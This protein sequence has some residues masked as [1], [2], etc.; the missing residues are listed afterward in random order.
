MVKVG[1]VREGGSRGRDR[2][3][4]LPSAT[5]CSVGFGVGKCAWVCKTAAILTTRSPA[6]PRPLSPA[7]LPRGDGQ[8][9]PA[10]TQIIPQQVRGEKDVSVCLCVPVGVCVSPLPP[11]APPGQRADTGKEGRRERGGNVS[12]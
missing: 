12:A 5:T 10:P 9:V 3:S 2:S 11:A 6:G 8:I 1:G 4:F 7:V